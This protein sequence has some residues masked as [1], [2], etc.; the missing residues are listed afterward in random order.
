MCI[1]LCVFTTLVKGKEAGMI[2][3]TICLTPLHLWH[4]L[5][6]Y[7]FYFYFLLYMSE[8]SMK[9]VIYGLVQFFLQKAAEARLQVRYFVAVLK[10]H[11]WP[12]AVV[13]LFFGLLSI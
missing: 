2:S 12:S 13:H 10:T 1:A 3:Q 8:F 4:L 5:I 6:L 9:S 7:V 11:W